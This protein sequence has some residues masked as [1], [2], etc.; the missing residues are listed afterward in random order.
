[1]S[2][3]TY[4]SEDKKKETLMAEMASDVQCAKPRAVLTKEQAIDIFRLSISSFPKGSRPTATS[5]ARAFGVSEKTIRDIWNGRTWCDETLPLDLSRQPKP[6][7]KT[8]RPLGCKDSAPRRPREMSRRANES[9]CKSTNDIQLSNPLSQIPQLVSSADSDQQKNSTCV[10]TESTG[11]IPDKLSV[12]AQFFASSSSWAEQRNGASGGSNQLSEDLSSSAFGN[13]RDP[14]TYI[15][16]SSFRRSIIESST[17]SCKLAP[18][19]TELPWSAPVSPARV[20][21]PSSAACWPSPASAA[22][23][24][25]AAFNGSQAQVPTLEQTCLRLALLSATAARLDTA[26]SLFPFDPALYGPRPSPPAPP[27]AT[28][29]NLAAAP[30]PLPRPAAPYAAGGAA[31]DPP[32]HCRFG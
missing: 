10:L 14:C 13:R 8:G 5:V 25:A 17:P 4:V 27:P 7:K 9:L 31:A 29:W 22:C 6:R 11:L 30:P 26:A 24:P 12:N 28:F 32:P 21:P 2:V 20:A 16:L 1:M 23:W 19:S 3:R 18:L 15:P